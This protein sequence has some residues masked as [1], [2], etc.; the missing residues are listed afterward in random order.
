M[1]A[2]RKVQKLTFG[3]CAFAGL[4]LNAGSA[5]AG[6]G[7]G[8]FTLPDGSN[9]KVPTFYANSPSGMLSATACFDSAGNAITPTPGSACDT[10]K[11]IQKFVDPLP[12]LANP[13]GFSLKDGVTS[14]A[15]PMGKYI[16]VA[17]PTKWINTQGVTTSDDYYEIAVGKEQKQ[18]NDGIKYEKEALIIRSYAHMNK[19]KTYVQHIIKE[20]NSNIAN[21]ITSI[22]PLFKK[23]THPY[24]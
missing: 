18:N 16:P 10:G 22:I 13:G 23:V 21:D 14:V 15:T 12:P 7:W 24:F 3:L 9:K 20:C 2:I 1:D 8:D 5:F 19:I 11:A 17:V 6:D 4:I